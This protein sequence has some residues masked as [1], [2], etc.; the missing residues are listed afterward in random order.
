MDTG[1]QNTNA[2]YIDVAKHIRSTIRKQ[3]LKPGDTLGTEMGFVRETGYSRKSI[4]SAIALLVDEGIV[5]RLPGK[6]LVVS[7]P[8]PPRQRISLIVPGLDIGSH[9][10]VTQGILELAHQ[11]GIDIEIYDAQSDSERDLEY[12]RNLT[13]GPS[14]GA[15]LV[16]LFL[17]EF[18]ELV[19]A[20]NAQGFPMAVVGRWMWQGVPSVLADYRTGGYEAAKHLIQQGHQHIGILGTFE[21]HVAR[22]LSEGVRDAISDASMV[23]HRELMTTIGLD[24]NL[25]DAQVPMAL[26][27]IL[28]AQTP[29]TAIICSHDAIAVRV[30]HELKKRNLRIPENVSVIGFDDEPFSQWM[31][32]PL[33][34]IKPSAKQIGHA[35]LEMIL[36]KLKSPDTQIDN[37]LLPVELIQRQSVQRLHHA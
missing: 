12:I 8:T 37:Q 15:I 9:L 31:D 10:Q 30:I 27:R 11:R 24:R 21:A 2:I 20:L 16:G 26:D 18:S 22:D 7:D 35:A 17:P 13:K 1:T 28:K 19:Y 23:F 14:H 4:R 29:P 5:C 34:T 36:Q 3:D 25:W 33:T 32:P 6:G